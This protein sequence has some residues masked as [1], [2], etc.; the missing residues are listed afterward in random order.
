[1]L[2][3]I[4]KVIKTQPQF[5]DFEQKRFDLIFNFCQI[6]KDHELQN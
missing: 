5:L 3:K 6:N 4:Y 1:M 2:L